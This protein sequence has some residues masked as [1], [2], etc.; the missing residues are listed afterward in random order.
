[1]HESDAC[2]IEG[3][4]SAQA[5][6]SLRDE[7]LV[8]FGVHSWSHPNLRALDSNELEHEIRRPWEWLRDRYRNARPW[9]AY[10]YG[11]ADGATT[12]AAQAAGMSLGF[13]AHY[14]WI[15]GSTASPLELHRYTVGAGTGMA[16]FR[17]A[18]C[19]MSPE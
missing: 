2:P 3:I 10:P 6:D 17:L 9:I 7:P 4:A 8:S 15:R 13:V 12:R 1:L 16:G 5:L 18:V 19:G 14:G 11:L